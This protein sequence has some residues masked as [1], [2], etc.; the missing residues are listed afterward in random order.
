MLPL[1][2]LLALPPA[3]SAPPLAHVSFGALTGV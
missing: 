1:L 3:A 2:A